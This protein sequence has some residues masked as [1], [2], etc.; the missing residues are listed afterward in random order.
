MNQPT[1][2]LF[3]SRAQA[4][5]QDVRMLGA[6][7]GDILKEQGSEALFDRVEAIRGAA[8]RRRKGEAGAEPELVALLADLQVDT[9]QDVVRA[10]AAYFFVVN[11]AERIHR[12]RRAVESQATGVPQAGSWDAVASQLAEG[13]V[14][15]KALTAQIAKLQI[16]PV[17]T[18][19]PTEA[20]PRAVLVKEQRI[21]R[22]L[23]NGLMRDTESMSEAVVQQV[24]NELTAA[25]QTDEHRSERPS[26][27]EEVEH[28][29]FYLSE[30]IYRVVPRFYRNLEAALAKV[31]GPV[32]E[33][34][35]AFLSFGSWVGGDMD[36]NPNVG[37]DTIRTTLARHQE[38]CLR[39]YRDELRELFGYLTQSDSMVS[40]DAAL[41]ARIAACRTAYPEICA[42]IPA[43]FHRMP[44]RML[45]WFI[46]RR[47][48]L[49][50]A[51]DAANLYAGPEDFLADLRLIEASL[52]NNKG[53]HAGAFLVR[54]LIRRAQTFGFHLASLDVRQHAAVHRRA[55]AEILQDPGFAQAP[56]AV[57]VARLRAALAQALVVPA[58]L[59]ADTRRCLDV[60][61]ALMDIRE[62]YGDQAVGIFIISMAQGPD[63]ALAL[64]LLARAAGM[65]AQD[66]TVALD[67]APL[68]ETVDDLA[69]ARSTL[70]ALWSDPVYRAHLRSRDDLQYVMLGYSD[71]NKDSGIGSSRWA[72]HNT[73]IEIVAAARK[74]QVHTTL[75]HGRG[76]SISR[77]GGRPRQAIL[78]EPPGA[79]GGRLR[80]TEQGEI[81][82]AK[83]GLRGLAV[84][85]LDIMGAAVLERLARA[86]KPEVP[87]DWMAAFAEVAAASRKIYRDLVYGE[88]D[89]VAYFRAATPI[90]VIERMP[91]GS[92]PARRGGLA[93][94]EDLR[95]IPWVFA[96]T[97]S[98]HILPGWFG[99]GTGL[100]AAQARFGMPLLRQMAAQWPAFENLISDVEMALAKSDLEIARR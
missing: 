71:S 37:P 23:V 22:A 63:D 98:R 62:D 83:F 88:A 17:F 53:A 69:S 50:A 34:L 21:A 11:M 2:K 32:A 59:G 74:A 77:G 84:R 89:F 52:L 20:T 79:V 25:W 38:L 10:F 27:A 42:E 31:G 67:I 81:I 100:E 76:G 9:T 48:E 49:T 65:Q 18:A 15:A 8:R 64:L 47:I 99:V 56:P 94:I 3:D 54:R 60:M 92:R 85:T 36:G 12:I 46:S 19:H 86:K 24:R 61:Q 35:P 97:Q 51:A 14:D 82:H 55:V 75:F 5:R 33:E 90:D 43:R 96:W 87:A 30:V 95:A 66:G 72:L 70:E 93:G 78:G 7:L 44:Y 6:L 91:I 4:L 57:R 41:R 39:H 73:Q 13:G 40:V 1:E 29:V 45:L 80:V 16:H 58:Q 28:I 68:F 26:V